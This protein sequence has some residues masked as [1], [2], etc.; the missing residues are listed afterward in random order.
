MCESVENAVRN[1]MKS[2]EMREY[3]QELLKKQTTEIVSSIN[4]ADK[5]KEQQEILDLREKISQEKET[6]VEL[7]R[8]ISELAKENSDLKNVLEAN[9]FEMKKCLEYKGK[10]EKENSELV[11]QKEQLATSLIDEQKKLEKIQSTLEAEKQK[12]SEELKNYEDRFSLIYNLY[13]VYCSLPINIKQR[14]CNIF[15]D[16]NIYSMI[17]AVSK[18]DSIEGLWGFTKRRIIEDENEGLS[19]LVDLFIKSFKLYS[20]I[21]GSGRYELI[22]PCV[23]DRFDSDKYSIKGIKTDGVVEKVLLRGIY[24]SISKKIIFKAVVQIL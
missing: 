15:A 21:D 9:A 22:T 12:I 13:K 19:E 23:G 17:V 4:Y 20:V 7:E 14:I 18:W 11:I 5:K 3:F 16:D 10:L 2:E 6:R 24:D 1:M 8:K